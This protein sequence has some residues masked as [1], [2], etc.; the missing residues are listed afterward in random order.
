[1]TSHGKRSQ[2]QV[3]MTK[4]DLGGGYIGEGGGKCIGR[5]GDL[6]KCEVTYNKNED[7]IKDHTVYNAIFAR[8]LS[9]LK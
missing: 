3:F 4:Y 7:G 6:K 1:M 9:I 8:Q 2:V 5:G